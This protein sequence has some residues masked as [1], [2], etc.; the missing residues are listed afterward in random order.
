M[1]K[2]PVGWS[3]RFI[4]SERGREQCVVCKTVKASLFCF[5]GQRDTEKIVMSR[6]V[7]L[8]WNPQFDHVWQSFLL[9]VTVSFLSSH[10][11]FH[12]RQRCHTYPC[13]CG[14][15]RATTL[16]SMQPWPWHKDEHELLHRYS[17]TFVLFAINNIRE[18]LWERKQNLFPLV[19]DII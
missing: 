3:S 4:Q 16:G 6:H 8:L 7:T 11:I 15:Q 14:K 12:A 18:S 10:T 1:A 17:F 5:V 2:I 9:I 19:L 13:N